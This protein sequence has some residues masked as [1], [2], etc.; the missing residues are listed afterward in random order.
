MS[1]NDLLNIKAR[2]NPDS[3]LR[4]LVKVACISVFV[5]VIVSSCGFYQVFSTFVIKSAE[6]DSVQLCRL[7]LEEQRDFML[8]TRPGKPVELGLHG[9]DTL[10]FDNKLRHFLSP[11]DIIKVKIYD[12]DK[13]IVYSTDATLIGKVDENNERLK[14]ALTGAVDAKMVTKDHARDLADEPLLDVDVVETYVPILSPDKRVL[15]SFEVYTNMTRYRDQI[16]QGVVLVTSFLVLVLGAVFGFT[17]ALI[18]GGTGQL[19]EAQAQLELVS[20]TDPLT[21]MHNRGFLMRRGEEEFARVLR[22]ARPLGCIMIDLDHFKKVNDTKG[23]AAGDR[24][25][26]AA[27]E[28]L[29]QSV[30]PYDVVGRYGGEEFMVLLPDAT[31]EQIVAVA[32]RMCAQ[33]QKTPFELEG[34]E[35]IPVTISLGVACFSKADRSLADLI[36]RAD[37]GLYKAKADGRNRVAW[38]FQP[39]ESETAA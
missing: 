14:N 28:R 2:N 1:L 29:Q 35:L 15:G 3:L 33:I 36:K 20:I 26:I 21:G 17:Y 31:F 25:L 38:V 7:L 18:R 4:L 16:R 12:P 6:I 32:N 39:G 11:F 34:G 5:V 22:S 8:N 13:K 9:N 30:R 10:L 24:V 37:D 19:K 23:H 27:A